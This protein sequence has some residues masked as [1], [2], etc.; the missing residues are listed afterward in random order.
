MKTDTVT[1]HILVV[2]DDWMNREVMEANL[3]MAGY[4]VSLAHDG[5]E[6]LEIAASDPPDLAL[7]D[8]K[9]PGMD[10]Y[11]VCRRL[12]ADACTQSAPVVM[13]TAYVSDQD[14]QTAIDAGADDFI[15]KPVSS[16][17]MFTRIKSLV[18]IKR[19]SDELAACQRE[20]ER[21][22]SGEK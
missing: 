14:R 9:M 13:I 8:V 20:L 11:E 5:E 10:G 18:R 6:A 3:T 22:R 1:A 16:L 17:V 4:R 12:K 19:L 2:D 7:L 21:L 15:N